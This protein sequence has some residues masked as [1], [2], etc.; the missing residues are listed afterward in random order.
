[1]YKI[2]FN[3]LHY[4][5]KIAELGSIVKAA[6]S[7][8][9]TQPGLSHQLRLLEEDLEVKLFDRIGK[10]LVLNENGKQVLNH[11]QK[12]FR[13]SEEL[14]ES[15]KSE[16][17]NTQKI[18]KIGVIPWISND[19]ILEFIKPALANKYIKLEVYQ[20]DLETLIKEIKSNKLD[21]IICD[22]QYSGRSKKIRGQILYTDKIFCLCSSK[23]KKTKRF[24][25]ILEE[26]TI[27]KYSENSIISE[28]VDEFLQDG[29]YRFDNIAEFSDTSLILRTVEKSHYISF[30]PESVAKD[31]IKNKR[32]K[33]L[34]VIPDQ[35]V[36]YWAL[37]NTQNSS[38]SYISEL[39]DSFKN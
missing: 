14:I 18:I 8:N 4:F 37:T 23:L 27:I 35:E 24:P 7:L 16:H 28:L 31:S 6:K 34:G 17:I 29:N 13:Q 32:V 30:L 2:N 33:K 3:H 9:M 1:M 22:S 15:V 19:Q 26:S 20:K 11:A 5:L 25:K 10:K 21:L 36:S 12:I 39:I 38:N